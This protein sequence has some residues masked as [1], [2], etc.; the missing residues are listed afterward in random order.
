MGPELLGPWRGDGR[1]FK[2]TEDL[3]ATMLKMPKA[4]PKMS[5]LV[6]R[7]AAEE[8]RLVL[9]SLFGQPAA[10]VNGNLCLGAFGPRLFFRLSE[11]DRSEA[12][13]IVGATVFEPAPGR[14]MR[15]Y[16]VMPPSLI[17][18]PAKLRLWARRSVEFTGALPAKGAGK[19]A[20]RT[21]PRPGT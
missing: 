20:A 5:A 4:D 16:L 11:A 10:F 19:R 13:T 6:G 17:A 2:Q 15:E 3:S 8:P 14:P 7:L 9:R 18:S 12:G 1:G 21:G